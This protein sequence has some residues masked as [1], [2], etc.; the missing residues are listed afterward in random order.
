[1]FRLELAN[2]IAIVHLD[3][4]PVN[5]MSFGRW[6]ELPA[7]I[8]D[9]ES[10]G[11]GAI[12]FSGAPHKHFCGGNDVLEFDGITRAGTLQ[13]I[14]AVRDAMRAVT[15]S[16]LPSVAALHG[17]VMGSGL[18]LAA[19]CD[20]RLATADARLALPEVKVGAYGGYAMLKAH[21]P[22][23]VAR[24]LTL[25]GSPI[26]GQRAFDL[27]FVHE[28]A[29]DANGVLERALTL[30]TEVG[31]NLA[32]P[33]GEQIKAVMNHQDDNALWPA[34]DIER[35]YAASIMGMSASS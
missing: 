4:P 11:A 7:V 13:G 6:A 16:T 14:G 34:Y 5:A 35:D 26:S 19:A 30:A 21:L 2:G 17:A 24:A 12:V 9:A 23:G 20:I 1:M 3:A 28:L 27:G 29:A 32:S 8:H 25:L 33:L 18:I 22:H 10:S 15:C 31:K